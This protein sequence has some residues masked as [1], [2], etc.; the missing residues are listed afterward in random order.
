MNKFD[1]EAVAGCLIAITAGVICSMFVLAVKPSAKDKYNSC[2]E[3]K[4][5]SLSVAEAKALCKELYLD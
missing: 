1:K 3:T 5:I 4:S 2:V